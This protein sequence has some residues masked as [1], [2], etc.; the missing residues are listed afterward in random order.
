[1]KTIIV[2]YSLEGSTRKVAE[3][4]SE[5]LNADLLELVPVK[6]V[7]NNGLKFMQG[8][9]QVMFKKCPKLQAYNFNVADYDRVILGTPIWAG[10]FTPAIRTFLKEN[11]LQYKVSAVFTLSGSGKSEGCLKKLKK[12]CP[13]IL[14]DANLLDTNDPK[15]A[16]L[17][18]RRIK[19][20]ISR[21]AY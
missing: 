15:N 14:N 19:N 9:G 18:E 2:Y 20:F 13:S 6:P 1:M 3:R 11:E 7:K 4:L 12:F 17:N 21:V 16:D 8:G 10:C 5:D